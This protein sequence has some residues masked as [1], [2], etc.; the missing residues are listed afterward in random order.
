MK[1]I[2]S[3]SSNYYLLPSVFEVLSNK[4]HTKDL[5]KASF[6]QKKLSTP[7]QTPCTCVAT[8]NSAPHPINRRGFAFDK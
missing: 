6:V 8:T 3:V 1:L 2:D 7:P 5:P 4:L